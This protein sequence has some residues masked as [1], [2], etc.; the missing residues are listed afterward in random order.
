[1]QFILKG[2]I[3]ET[4]FRVFTF[5]GIAD[6]RTRTEFKVRTDLSLIRRYGIRVQDLPLLCRGLLERHGESERTLTFTEKEMSTHAA[7]SRADREAAE[8]RKSRHAPPSP[9]EWGRPA[10]SNEAMRTPVA[11]S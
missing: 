4:G 7:N 11:K 8:R 5:E 9:R 10:P 1:M 3:P 2:F 6:D